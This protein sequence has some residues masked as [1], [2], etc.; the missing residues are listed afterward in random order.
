MF[1][2]L[3]SYLAT[4]DG[5]VLP[6]TR[7]TRLKLLISYIQNKID[8][9]VTPVLQF[10]CTHNSRRSQ[11]AQ[12]WAHTAAAHH[13]IPLRALSG[14]TEATG[15]H[16]NA[17][18]SIQRSGFII[19]QG[20]QMEGQYQYAVRFDDQ[21]APCMVFSKRFDDPSNQAERFAAVMTC[22]DADEHCP[23]IPGT[24]QRIALNYE[25]P[26]QADGTE[27]EASTYDERQLQI[28]AE[29]NYVFKHIKLP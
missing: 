26:K 14:G 7:E 28:A 22:S 16:P 19:D 25:D 5:Y 27:H 1:T 8:Q 15:F 24:E 2:K 4:L 11:F 6:E 13:N 18:A 20:I 23:F 17:Q 10:I 29:M 9:G 12:I 21:S 3:E